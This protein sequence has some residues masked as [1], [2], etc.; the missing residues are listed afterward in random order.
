MAT[1][2][3]IVRRGIFKNRQAANTL[4]LMGD[5]NKLNI[6]VGFTA[7]MAS[8]TETLKLMFHLV[9]ELQ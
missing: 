7:P 3:L 5:G 9:A 4:T 1:L 2:L 6:T 8:G